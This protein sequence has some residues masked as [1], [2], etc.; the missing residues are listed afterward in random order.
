MSSSVL[1]EFSIKL[2]QNVFK[3]GQ[4][5]SGKVELVLNLPVRIS[6]LITRFYGIANVW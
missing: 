5:L 3:T 2:D 1:S 6:A 4:K